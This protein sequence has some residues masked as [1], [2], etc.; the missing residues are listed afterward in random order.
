MARHNKREP[1]GLAIIG[2]G[3]LGRFRGQVAQQYPGVE[4]IGL[5]DL[6]EDLGRKLMDELQADYFTTDY[7]ELLRRPEV[8]A[9]LIATEESEHVPLALYAA[10]RGHR[11][12]IEKPLATNARESA[13]VLQAI[14]SAGVDAVMGYT[15]RFRRRF[16]S[17]KERV[18]K[19]DLGDV[20]SVTT[21]AFLN[22]MSAIVALRLD[23]QPSRLTPMVSSG[24]H[25]LDLSLW[26]LEGKTPVELYARS[27]DKVFGKEWGT[28]DATFG[29]FTFDDGTIWSMCINWALPKRWPGSTYG[30]EL[31][32]VGTK[33]VITIDDTHRDIVM[34]TDE[35]HLDQRAD[36]WRNV[37]FLTSFPPGDMALGQ[38]RGPVREET[39]AWLTRLYHGVPTPHATAAEG[40]RNLLLTM[41]MDLSA[42]TG[43]PVKLPIAP[44]ELSPA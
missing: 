38:L 31:G 22:S 10:E 43:K 44:E 41:A 25:S 32:I 7:K 5:C 18:R 19:G 2:C 12:M 14:E 16:L 4:W 24:T 37:S 28:K 23:P 13:Q 30:I 42:R 9:V 35:P 27:V 26:F 40:H 15:Q 29:V 17:A 11:L 39:Y 8:N 3:R 6:K 33:G 20:T 21:R 34:A 36:D 1:I